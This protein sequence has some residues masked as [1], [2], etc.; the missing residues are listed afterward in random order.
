MTNPKWEEIIIAAPTDSVFNGTEYKWQGLLVANNETSN[1]IV[2]HI[3]GILDMECKHI[4]RGDKKDPTPKE[5]NAEINYGLKQPIPYG[6]VTSDDRDGELRV[7]VYE[8]LEGGTESRL[9]GKLSI[10]V[11]GHMNVLPSAGKPFMELVKE[12]ASRELT[13]ELEF[14][15]VEGEVDPG[16]YPVTVIGLLNDERDDVG[17]VHLG[18]LYTV[19]TNPNH[20]VK[21]RE[22]ENLRGEW[23]TLAEL[24]TVKDRLEGWSEIALEALKNY[25]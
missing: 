17:K 21:V 11:G 10:G 13:E 23:M 4:R 9:Q 18:I 15:S 8:R 25:A 6:I 19:E 20:Y 14:G 16:T 5:E 24:E 7:F 3:M 22:T 12:E 2:Q 1:H